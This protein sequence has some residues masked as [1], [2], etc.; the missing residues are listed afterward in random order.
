MDYSLPILLAI[1]AAGL[2][3]GVIGGLAGIGGSLII[4]PALHAILGDEP[5]SV[6]HLYMGAAMVVNVAV[7]FPAALRHARSG[8]IRRDLLPALFAWTAFAIIAGVL[9]GNRFSG[10]AL[11]HILAGFILI[12]CIFNLVRIARRIEDH[13]PEAERTGRANIALSGS[14]TGFIG[15]LLGLGG[16]VMLVPM[17]QMLCR[18]PLRSSIATSSAV[19]CMTAVIGAGLK[20]ATLSGEGQSWTA[21]L[22]LAALLAPTAMIGGVIGASLTHALP[23]NAVRAAVTIVLLASAAK[24][25]GAW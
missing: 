25:A 17:L 21:A 2:G 23:I 11:R 7:S 5:A 3:A 6:H 9:V 12:Y 24:L 19:I 1:L 18:V 22:G 4:L 20:L 10:D 14:F 8:A 16:G 13:P 15:G